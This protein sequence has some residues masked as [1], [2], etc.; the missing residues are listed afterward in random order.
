MRTKNSIRNIIFALGGQFVTTIVNMINKTVFIY[1]LGANYLGVSG[2]FSNILSMLS[3]AELGIGS[4]ITF[5]MYKPLAENNKQEIK[6]LMNLYA[7]TYKIIG[8]FIAIIGIALTPFLKYIIKDMPNIPNIN[9]IYIMFLLNSVV[10]YFFAYKSAIINADQKNYIVTLKTQSFILL[11]SFVQIMIL[12]LTRNYVLYLVVQIIITLLTNLSISKKADTM[13]PYIKSKNIKKINTIKKKNIFKQ[14]RAMMSHKIGTVIINGTDNILISSFVGI[15]W[16]GIYSNY[17]MI[18]YMI[19]GFI[20]QIFNSITSSIGNL[21]AKET[22]EKSYEIYKKLLF[23]N[24]WIYGFSSICFFILINPFIELWIGKEYILS[25]Y[26]VIIIV[27]NFYM[28]GIRTITLAYRDTL[29]LFWNDRYKPLI[30]SIINLIASIILA[31]NFGLI[32]VLIGTFIS[33]VL[34]SFWIE[35]YVLFKNGFDR[36]VSDYFKLFIKYSLSFTIILLI[37][38]WF[39]NIV[40]YKDIFGFLIKVI[41]TIT[42]PNLIFSL[43]F[44]RADE[45]KYFKDNFLKRPFLKFK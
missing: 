45:F 9:L 4:T 20:R 1:I 29:G 32:G 7:Q 27:L 10:S 14:V 37:T 43:F 24:F 13:Y 17:I 22:K 36:K 19:N 15:Y 41:I 38:V 33:T 12:F 30:E 23:F 18:I 39:C 8:I 16:V 34:T 35:P 44:Y 5:H 6:S 25:I 31:N 11:Q 26:I 42:L 28:S 40:N 3:L 2:L 21:N